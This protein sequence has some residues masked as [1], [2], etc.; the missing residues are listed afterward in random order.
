MTRGAIPKAPVDVLLRD[1]IAVGRP[2]AFAPRSARAGEALRG[3]AESPVLSRTRGCRA[4]ASLG[5]AR[6]AWPAI[7]NKCA[8]VAELEVASNWVLPEI[9]IEIDPLTGPGDL[10]G[11]SWSVPAEA[12]WALPA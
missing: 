10:S 4:S 5:D 8:A 9:A 7:G 11:D 6:S 3:A 1:W 12:A 2:G